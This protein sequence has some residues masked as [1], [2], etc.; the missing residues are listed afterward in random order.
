MA[1]KVHPLVHESE[2]FDI[3][4]A[5]LRAELERTLVALE[6]VVGPTITVTVPF[7][8][9]TERQSE[10][11]SA[12]PGEPELESVRFDWECI[13][14]TDDEDAETMAPMRDFTSPHRFYL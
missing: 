5:D 1:G 11:W 2:P 13:C 6:A 4:I 12:P 10:D 3:S 8:W 7:Y 14:G 9:S